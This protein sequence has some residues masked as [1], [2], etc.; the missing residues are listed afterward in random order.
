MA[1]KKPSKIVFCH[2]S[3]PLV[4]ELGEFYSNKLPQATNSV[5]LHNDS[6]VG[7]LENEFYFLNA[8]IG[9]ETHIITAAGQKHYPTNDPAIVAKLEAYL[10]ELEGN[11]AGHAKKR[12]VR[13]SVEPAFNLK[14]DQQ[15]YYTKVVADDHEA[16]K[17]VQELRLIY[18][19]KIE[20]KH[21]SNK[22]KSVVKITVRV[23]SWYLTYEQIK[24]AV[25]QIQ[26]A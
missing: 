4:E 26:K 7:S 15:T 21:F 24:V 22:K 23:L 20:A 16:I 2:Y 18:D 11:P 8:R 6:I 10:A 5:Q 17:V 9:K 3:H 19:D 12:G 13:K 25:E 1:Q 14:L